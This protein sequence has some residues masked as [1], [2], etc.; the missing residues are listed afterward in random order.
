MLADAFATIALGFSAALG[1]PFHAG[2]ARWPGTPVLDEG[3]SIAT[4]GVPVFQDCHV[5]VDVAG[6]RMRAEAGFTEKDK[7]MIVLGLADLDTDATI[8]VLE[9][10][11]AGV[12]S[13]QSCQRD[14]GAI[15]WTVRARHG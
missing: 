6:E 13:V 10:P 5:Q 7:A 11:D 9:G 8:E 12:W 1:G 15:G 3:G 2:R 14:P 4:P